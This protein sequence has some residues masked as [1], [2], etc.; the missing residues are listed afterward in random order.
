MA[1]GDPNSVQLALQ[2]SVI[3]NDPT[4]AWLAWAS[5][6]AFKPAWFD[7]S[8]HFTFADAGSPLKV[9]Q[10]RNYPIKA[11]AAVDNTCR[12]LVGSVPDPGQ[13]VYCA[14]NSP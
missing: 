14:P 4:F 2:R 3:S 10:F 1:P 5:R 11:L 12:M 8:D 9:E 6:D 7:Y 13:Q